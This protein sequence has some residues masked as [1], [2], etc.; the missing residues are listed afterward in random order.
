MALLTNPE[1]GQG[2]AIRATEHARARFVQRGVDVEVLSGDSAQRS[3]ELARKAVAAGV[4][5]LVVVGGDGLISLVLQEIAGSEV[6]MGIIPAGTG[7]DLARH[8]EIPRSDAAAAADVVLDG[9]VS[10]VD[11]GCA[12]DTLFGTVVATGF[13]S[14]VTRR[15]NAM[16]WPKGSLRYTVA[17]LV[18]VAW[19]QPFHYRIELDDRIVETDAL[20]VAVGNTSWY[21]GGMKICPAADPRDGMLDVT[22][23]GVTDRGRVARLLPT[24]FSG[25]H[26]EIEGVSTYRSRRVRL[27]AHTTADTDGEPLGTLPLDLHAEP[28]ALRLLI[29]N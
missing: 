5:A 10:T 6:P 28:A 25:R 15:A 14:R 13:D 9:Q 12:G 3:R 21:G 11:L 26:V 17:A 24:I 4:E 8:F 7:N 27:D 1:S 2:K 29:P 18:E 23:V 16:R 19:L 22:V 20:L